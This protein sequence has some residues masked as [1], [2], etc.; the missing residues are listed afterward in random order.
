MTLV[1]QS[2]L[3]KE[4]NVSRQYINRLVK[5]GIFAECLEGKK[6][7]LECA[8]KAYEASRKIF[9]RDAK[10]EQAKQEA[11]KKTPQA[12]KQDRELFNAQNVEE[13]AELLVDVFNPSQ[14]VQ[15]IKEYWA[16]KLNEIKFLKESGKLVEKSEVEN[17]LYEVALAIREKLLN[18]PMRVANDLAG[19]SDEFEIRQ[20]LEDEIREAL[21]DLSRSLKNG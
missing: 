12:I 10:F 9:T 8:K 18:I 20:I 3:A 2:Q 14:K 16:G 17:E 7:R 13:L 5:K 4:L 11:I 1:S 15:I 21:E 19:K 6:L